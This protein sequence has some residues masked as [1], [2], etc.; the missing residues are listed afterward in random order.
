MNITPTLRLLR[1]RSA[2]DLYLSANAIPRMRVEGKIETIGETPLGEEEIAGIAAEAMS[3][4]QRERFRNE[5]QVEFGVEDRDSGRFRFTVFRQRGTTAIAIRYIPTEI[6][7]LSTLKLPPILGELAMSQRGLILVVGVS[8]AGKSTTL[9]AM[10]D[11]RN[12][13]CADHI[14]TIEDPIEY[15]HRHRLSVVNQRE[16]FVDALS[17]PLAMRSALRSAPDIVMVGEIHDRATMSAVINLAN[18]GHLALSTLHTTNAAQTLDRVLSMFPELMQQQ[19]R[20]DLSAS[21][22]AVVSQRLLNG[23]DGRL[24]P[25]VEVMLN[26][27]YIAELIR[28]NRLH[29]L[30]EAMEES[31]EPGM[32]SFDQALSTLYQ[33][34]R[35]TLDEALANADSRANLEARIHFA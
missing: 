2:S 15:V 1:E 10:L 8:G 17:Y 23:T 6:P 32:Q 16:L 12:R 4:P 28:D 5:L 27:P 3:G 24:L 35:I 30:R 25:A 26:T 9:A 13:E 20:L 14:I 21:L 11:K 22:R 19:V 33:A 7:G 18:T 34:G 31:T 29:E